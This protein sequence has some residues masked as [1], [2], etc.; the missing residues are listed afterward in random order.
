MSISWATNDSL[1]IKS[2]TYAV[3]AIT[4]AKQAP[5]EMSIDRCSRC[6]CTSSST[7]ISSAIRHVYVCLVTVFQKP[8]QFQN[9]KVI[10]F[11]EAGRRFGS[12]RPVMA[13]YHNIVYHVTPCISQR[14]SCWCSTKYYASN[15]TSCTLVMHI[16][17]CCYTIIAQPVWAAG[18]ALLYHVIHAVSYIW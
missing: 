8:E 11:V 15:W 13:S 14:T 18:L 1:C 5:S 10:T 6:T 17:Q 12:K 9:A 3:Q 4:S 7:A 2:L 16:I